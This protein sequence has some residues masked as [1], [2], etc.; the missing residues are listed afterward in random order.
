MLEQERFII[1]ET[2]LKELG[3]DIYR[4]AFIK[5]FYNLINFLE[6]DPSN[7]WF[8]SEAVDEMFINIPRLN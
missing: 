5:M 6:F 2:F 4:P 7:E 1:A 8:T 3:L